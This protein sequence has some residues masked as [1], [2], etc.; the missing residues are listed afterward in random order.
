MCPELSWLLETAGNPSHG[1][2]DAELEFSEKIDEVTPIKKSRFDDAQ[3]M[4]VIRHV[5]DQPRRL[6]GAVGS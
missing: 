1:C 6:G 2:G 5:W 3:I 4:T